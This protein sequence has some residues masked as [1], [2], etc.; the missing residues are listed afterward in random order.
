[1]ISRNIDLTANGDFGGNSVWE[2][3]FDIQLID[4]AYEDGYMS[5]DQYEQVVR[6]EGIFGRKRHTSAAG[7]IFDIPVP[8]DWQHRCA[9]CGKEIRAP[10]DNIYGLCSRCNESLEMDSYSRIPWSPF[11]IV[12]NRIPRDLFDLR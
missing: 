12:Y 2:L 6:W 10:W 4:R 11:K 8:K 1:M 7:K 5:V 9:R 3:P